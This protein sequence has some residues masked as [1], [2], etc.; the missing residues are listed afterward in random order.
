M[1]FGK[2]KG[3]YL[4]ELPDEYLTWIC[5]NIELRAPLKGALESE[6]R[7]RLRTVT[8]TTI[9]IDPKDVVIM[10]EIVDRGVRAAAK[11]H[12]PDAGG[13]SSV[14]VRVNAIAHKL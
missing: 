3:A 1:P 12:H 7:R 13:D 10:R 14:M 5:P 6:M 11:V 2:H 4:T 9:T 8:T